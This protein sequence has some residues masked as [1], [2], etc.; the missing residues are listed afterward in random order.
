MTRARGQTSAQ[1]L[2][3]ANTPV[4]DRYRRFTA[5]W[6]RFIKPLLDATNQNS[7]DITALSADL[8]TAQA[9]I[10]TEQTVRADA[11]AALASQITTLEAT[12]NTDILALEAS[13]ATE[14]TARV[15]GDGAL[16][17]QITTLETTVNGNTAS[18]ATTQS[19]VNGIAAQYGVAINVNGQVVGLIRLDG[20]VT[21]STFTVLADKFIVSN[22][23]NAAQT[24]QAFVVGTVGGSA[25]VGI[26][27][28]LIV[29]G[30]IAARSI[31]VD[32]LSA[33]TANLGTVTAGRIQSADGA[34]FWDLSTG[35][36]QIGG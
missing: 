16:S 4:I 19:S 33:L 27:G 34:S 28:A 35:D 11:D 20:G 17:S 24:A 10:S 9:S 36:F 15:A 29:D 25:T 13:V 7:T 8:T 18:I 2:P 21:G 5:P 14:T 30:T 3:N 22:P 1:P 32:S 31:F 26:N 23:S 6:F 12:L